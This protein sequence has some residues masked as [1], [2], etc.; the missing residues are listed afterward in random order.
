MR[1]FMLSLSLF[2]VI[3]GGVLVAASLYFY[4][5]A[6][7]RGTKDFLRN[8]Q[9]LQQAQP[10]K[11]TAELHPREWLDQQPLETWEL[12]SQDRLRLVAHYLP[13]E[14]PNDKIVILAHGYTSQGKD[15][16]SFARFYREELGYHVLLP[17]AR[18]HGQSEG[19]YIGF[20]WPE[21]KDYL[22]WIET[23]IA[24]LGE[25]VQIALHG[26]SMG[27]ATV[28]MVSGETLPSQV[29]A[30]IE[31]CGYTSASDQLAYQLKRMYNLPV[32]P[33]LPATSVVT[34]IKAG[35]SLYEASALKQI[36]KNTRPILFIH[37]DED[38]FVPTGM[39]W[40]LYEACT[41]EKELYLVKGAGHGHAYGTDR[42][43]Y[44]QKVG[45]FLAR[46]LL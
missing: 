34:Q 14:E 16:A 28:M 25:D 24:R 20:G 3:L 26:L 36:E 37:G 4:D 19:D 31:D 29:K 12:E 44:I 2:V 38:R 33:L 42:D 43:T 35:Y 32:F 40:E 30:I 11:A 22:L 6:I 23:I 10:A 5:V 9:D 15:M 1:T 7:N 45:D 8:N 18:G 13:A 17:D 46:F 39:V 21:R 41:S 27:A